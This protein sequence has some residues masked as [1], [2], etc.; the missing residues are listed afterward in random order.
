M[1]SFFEFYGRTEILKCVIF[2]KKEV[3]ICPSIRPSLHL[4]SQS[5]SGLLGMCGGGTSN[6]IQV[7]TVCIFQIIFTMNLKCQQNLV[8]R[9]KSKQ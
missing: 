2:F 8:N 5:S 9:A 3:I 4:A 6:I 1:H 7:Y